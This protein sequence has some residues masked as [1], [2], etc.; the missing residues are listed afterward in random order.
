MIEM[1][2]FL[3]YLWNLQA[4]L[5]KAFS[6]KYIEVCIRKKTIFSAFYYFFHKEYSVYTSE[7]NAF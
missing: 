5:E 1:T 3:Q 6:T 2:K 4:N 7:V